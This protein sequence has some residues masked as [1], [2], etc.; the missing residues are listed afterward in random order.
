MLGFPDVQTAS[1][2]YALIRT[3]SVL[4]SL[5]VSTAY[6]LAVCLICVAR[7]ASI[8]EGQQGSMTKMHKWRGTIGQLNGLLQ[9][10]Q[11]VRYLQAKMLCI[12]NTNV[13]LAMAVTGG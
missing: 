12:F 5:Q 4:L 11:S 9:S 8:F 6:A 7:T 2:S 13:A 10:A 3:F 1:Y